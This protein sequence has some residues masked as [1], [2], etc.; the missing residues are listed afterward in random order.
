M[1]GDMRC[2]RPNWDTQSTN[3]LLF[4]VPAEVKIKMKFSYQLAYYSHA[5]LIST[6]GGDNGSV[7]FVS[8]P[9]PISCLAAAAASVRFDILV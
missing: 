3:S 5:A 8:L 7:Q 2:R 6:G 9:R 1:D 4:T